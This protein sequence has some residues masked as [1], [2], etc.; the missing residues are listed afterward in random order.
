LLL[1]FRNLTIGVNMNIENKSKS[2]NILRKLAISLILVGGLA[3]AAPTSASAAKLVVIVDVVTV[4]GEAGGGT[5]M[6]AVGWGGCG[7][8]GQ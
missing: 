5:V 4:E 7:G 6:A 3:A 1:F 2:L 8:C